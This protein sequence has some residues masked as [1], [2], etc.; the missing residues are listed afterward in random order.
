MASGYTITQV[1]VRNGRFT[2]PASIR[3]RYGIEPGSQV[4]FVGLG[5]SIYLLPPI[6]EEVLRRWQSL[7]GEEAVRMARQIVETYRWEAGTPAPPGEEVEA[8][9]RGAPAEEY[10]FVALAT[11]SRRGQVV[12]PAPLRV[13][14][15]G[16]LKDRIGVA[17]ADGT[18]YLFSPLRDPIREARGMFAGEPNLLV[19][20][21]EERARERGR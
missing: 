7:E 2:I 11:V 13:R 3:R 9:D 5:N 15:N 18:I 14:M 21:L 12:I 16:R 1:K 4:T 17:D 20:L 10:A 8:M 19:L 6:P